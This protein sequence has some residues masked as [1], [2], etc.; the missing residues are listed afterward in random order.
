MSSADDDNGVL[1]QHSDAEPDAEKPG[2]WGAAPTRTIELRTAPLDPRF[3]NVNAARQCYTAYNEFYRCL[4]QRG[5]GAPE[6]Q[7]YARTYRSIC[8]AEWL[9][10]WNTL[11]EEGRWFGKY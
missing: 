6:C 1:V 9:E 5:E 10:R 7:S 3:P 11:R 2:E 4:A 8:P